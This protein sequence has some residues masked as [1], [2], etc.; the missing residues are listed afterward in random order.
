MQDGFPRLRKLKE[1]GNKLHEHS[2]FISNWNKL[3]HY[4]IL[5]GPLNEIQINRQKEKHFCSS[6]SVFC[7]RIV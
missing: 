2:H 1:R 3:Q 5:F 6:V 4:A 7:R